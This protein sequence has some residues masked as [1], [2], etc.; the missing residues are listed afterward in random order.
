MTTTRHPTT[1]PTMPTQVSVPS[2]V[3]RVVWE[4]HIGY[5]QY[6]VKCSCTTSM[7]TNCR[8]WAIGFHDDV[9]PVC[10][11][12]FS[13]NATPTLPATTIERRRMIAAN[14]RAIRHTVTVPSQR[15]VVILPSDVITNMET[16]HNRIA[17]LFW[18]IDNIRR[19]EGT[20][21][22]ARRIEAIFERIESIRYQMARL[23][24][25]TDPGYA[26]TE[27][28]ET[29]F[30]IAATTDE[31]PICLESYE[32][33]RKAMCGHHA[34]SECCVS[35]KASGRTICCPLCRDKR[36]VGLVNHALATAHMMLCSV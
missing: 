26:V 7:G 17:F 10:Q 31:C 19:E 3:T 25:P 24:V 29:T 2:N 15:V 12:H 6:S 18:R 36:F 14:Q 30:E 22:G 11:V 21:F 4:P 27:I 20:R 23:F 33:T 1:Q 16:A 8:R 5:R 35:M 9:T 34:C 13:P 32:L 28:T